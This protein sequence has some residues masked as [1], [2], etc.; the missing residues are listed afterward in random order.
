[1]RS[2]KFRLFLG[3]SFLVF[4]AFGD[5]FIDESKDNELDSWNFDSMEFEFFGFLKNR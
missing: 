2:T 4:L 5:F 1:M 3:L